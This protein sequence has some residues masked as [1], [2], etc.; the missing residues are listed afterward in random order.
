MVAIAHPTIPIRA[1]RLPAVTYRRRRL[2]ALG[3]LLV[4]VALALVA[5]E[6]VRGWRAGGA[7]LEPTPVARVSVVVQP[8]DSVWSIAEEIRPGHDPRPV[9]D[10]IVDANGGAALVAGQRLEIALPR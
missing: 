3:L 9:V 4:I 5:A 1:P 2:A 6:A 7:G 8:G 10:A